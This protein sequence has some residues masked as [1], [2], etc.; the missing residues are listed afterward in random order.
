M[1]SKVVFQGQELDYDE[2][3]ADEAELL[4]QGGAVILDVRNADER[5]AYRVA[6][7][8]HIPLPELAQR[9]AEVPEGRVL[10]VCAKGLRSAAAAAILE[11]NG[12]TDISSVAGGTDGWVAAGKPTD[13]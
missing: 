3:D 12:R 2:V 8:I 9:A 5:A 1:R 7:S 4:Q 11:K 6:G 13:R 10:T